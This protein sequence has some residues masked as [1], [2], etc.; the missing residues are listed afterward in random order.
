MKLEENLAAD[1]LQMI[2]GN[3]DRWAP[4]APAEDAEA[5]MRAAQLLAQ[6]IAKNLAEA[7][8]QN[9]GE[10]SDERWQKMVQEA[11]RT[12]FIEIPGGPLIQMGQNPGFAIAVAGSTARLVAPSGSDWARASFSASGGV[13]GR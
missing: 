4:N 12:S 2:A 1:I 13:G 3:L 7:L 6:G 10:L 11:T 5:M 9:S 8:A